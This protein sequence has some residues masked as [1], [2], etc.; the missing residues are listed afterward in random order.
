MKTRS[1]LSGA[2]VAMLVLA[3]FTAL[4]PASAQDQ[5][6]QKVW[7]LHI[8]AVGTEP[9]SIEKTADGRDVFKVNPIGTVTG[10]LEGTYTQRITQVDECT[11]CYAVNDMIPMTGYFTIETSEGKMEGYYTGVFHATKDTFPDYKMKVQG[12]ILSVTPSYADLFLADVYYDGI[13]DFE[14][15]VPLGDSGEMNIVPR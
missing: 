2:I 13:V 3:L 12:Q 11:T 5:A 15:G 8:A 4:L 9:P 7:T 10:D 14:N 6:T 1:K